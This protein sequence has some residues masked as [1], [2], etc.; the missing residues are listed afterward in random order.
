LLKD[1]SRF[2]PE[3]RDIP[4][5]IARN[6]IDFKSLDRIMGA[7]PPLGSPYGKRIVSVGNLYRYKGIHENLH[8]L[9]AVLDRGMRDWTYRVVGDG[10]Y[11]KELESLA[12]S[13]GLGDMVT[14]TGKLTHEEALREMRDADLFSLPSWAEPFGNVYAE[15]AL[16]GVPA[17]GCHGQ[18][19]ELSI[20]DGETGFLVPPKDVGVLAAKIRYLLEHQDGSRSMGA[21]AREHIKQFTWEQTAEVYKG[22]MEQVVSSYEKRH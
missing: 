6:G 15:A 18:G 2:V 10:P 4:V 5:L 12:A 8:A 21:K 7:L 16:C 22:I 1:V 14:F 13:L 19:A 17:I 20:V 3:G 11:R 9:R